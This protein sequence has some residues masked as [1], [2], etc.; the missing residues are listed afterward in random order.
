VHAF[1]YQIECYVPKPRRV[2]GYFCL[3]LLY[4]D[5]FVGRADC[6]ARRAR[7]V[8]EVVHLH[9]EQQVPDRELFAARAAEALAA[10]AAF[11]GCSEVALTRT[12]P[13]ELRRELKRHLP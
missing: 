11:N 13:R 1:D 6:K 5:R 8:L 2:F 12:S 7:G 3:P 4:R 10:F 9:L